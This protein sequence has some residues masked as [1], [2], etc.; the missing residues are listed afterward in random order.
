MVL[1]P[2]LPEPNATDRPREFRFFQFSDDGSTVIGVDW[3][4]A[5]RMWD[6]ASGR[7]VNEREPGLEEVRATLEGSRWATAIS[8]DA[9]LLV[10]PPAQEDWETAAATGTSPEMTVENL[11]T[12]EVV[13]RFA[14]DTWLDHLIWVPDSNLLVGAHADLML[15]D[16]DNW[17]VRT[18]SRAQGARINDISLSPNNELVAT[19]GFDN[20]LVVWNLDDG[21][22]R[23]EIPVLGDVGET[24]RGVA[25]L[26][27]E[28][29]AVAPE[30]GDELLVFTLDRDR[31]VERA[32]ESLTRGFTEGECATYDIDPCPTLEDLRSLSGR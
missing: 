24:L 3:Y 4:G 20:H 17:S 21:G 13:G 8:P 10:D 31:L 26:D 18:F 2:P 9:S 6:V 14:I 7:V 23:A 32:L 1:R 29:I 12:G 11:G 15:V 22:I 16:S 30:I 19:V 25:F 27:D 5:V 28:T